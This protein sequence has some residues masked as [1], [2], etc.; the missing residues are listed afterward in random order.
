MKKIATL[1]TI[2]TISLS[3]LWAT[4]FHLELAP[5]VGIRN[6]QPVGNSAAENTMTYTGLHFQTGFMN[7]LIAGN[8][9]FVLPQISSING[10]K[11][12]TGILSD[13]DI[14]FK[15]FP[16]R[17]LSFWPL[18]AISYDCFNTNQNLNSSFNKSEFNLW[19]GMGIG[20][21]TKN[22]IWNFLFSVN[23][24]L[25]T[26][27]ENSSDAFA[28]GKITAAVIFRPAHI[29]AIRMNW[30]GYITKNTSSNCSCWCDTS[31]SFKF[32]IF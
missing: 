6:G 20:L 23:G 24:S 31:L 4:D 1:I 13:F 21:R 14:I 2:L 32:F 9:N 10:T 27:T 8:V 17:Y 7:F 15:F 29:F 30:A 22:D 18:T 19:A 25:F 5:A 26:K 16:N 12:V 11:E 3:G 28:A